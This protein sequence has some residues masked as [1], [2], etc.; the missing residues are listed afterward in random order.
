MNS[1]IKDFLGGIVYSSLGDKAISFLGVNRL[2]AG[3]FVCRSKR[4]LLAEAEKEFEK[5]NAPGNLK[6]YEHALK[7]HGVS[8]S[9]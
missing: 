5:G 6:D 9:E 1:T 8:F 4:R 7:K 3:L 2:H